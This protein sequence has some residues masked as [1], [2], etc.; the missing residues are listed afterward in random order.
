VDCHGYDGEPH[1]ELEIVLDQARSLYDCEAS[2]KHKES[3][4]ADD[5]FEFGRRNRS[6]HCAGGWW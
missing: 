6:C 4:G 5:D 2:R 1:V 3:I